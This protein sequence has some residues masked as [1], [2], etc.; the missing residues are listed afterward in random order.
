M[1][2]RRIPF[3]LNIAAKERLSAAVAELHITAGELDRR[4][5]K[6]LHKR[7]ADLRMVAGLLEAI[8][9]EGTI[10]FTGTED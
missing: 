6:D 3:V 7:A 5:S 4:P 10:T 2:E 1:P 9:D 8:R